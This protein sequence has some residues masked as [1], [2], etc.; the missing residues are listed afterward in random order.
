MRVFVNSR[1]LE[2]LQYLTIQRPELIIDYEA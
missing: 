2:S 1:S